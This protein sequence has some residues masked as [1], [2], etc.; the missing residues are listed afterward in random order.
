MYGVD[1]AI[2]LKVEDIVKEVFRKYI[3]DYKQYQRQ[4][5]TNH[6]MKFEDWLSFQLL[7]PEFI[8]DQALS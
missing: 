8:F 3:R 7:E 2:G 6:N 5:A 4:D 1:E